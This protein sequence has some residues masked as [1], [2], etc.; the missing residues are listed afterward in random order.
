MEF[1]KRIFARNL[2]K[3]LVCKCSS[4]GLN[5]VKIFAPSTFLHFKRRCLSSNQ[6]SSLTTGA[7]ERIAFSHKTSSIVC[8]RKYSSE[9]N[10]E[11]T[12]KLSRFNSIIL[13]LGAILNAN[14]DRKMFPDQLAGGFSNKEFTISQSQ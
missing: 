6:N 5:D 10:L 4:R 9:G 13:D 8:S 3:Q 2:K 11:W 14:T 12:W 1:T 7:R